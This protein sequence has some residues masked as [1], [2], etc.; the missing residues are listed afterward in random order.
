MNTT[1][2]LPAY[3]EAHNLP[4]VLE[5]LLAVFAALCY[6]E[7]QVI[8]VDDGSS[9]DTAAVA[10]RFAATGRVIVLQ[11][12]K[13]RGLAAAL[14]TGLVAASSRDGV[15]VTMDADDSHDPALIPALLAG[16]E[17]GNDVMIASRFQDGGGMVGVPAYRSLLSVAA[18]RAMR[19][20]FPDASIRDYSTGYRAYR[21]TLL[22]RLIARHGEGLLSQR[23]FAATVEILL[24]ARAEGAR[25]GEVPFVLRYDRKAGPSKMN[26]SATVAGYLRL[27]ISDFPAANL[28]KPRSTRV[29]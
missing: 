23:G 10:D 5:R 29:F 28:P 3:N 1:V 25:I 22:R 20:V 15:V 11:H 7:G 6:G 8:V 14:R 2:V 27:M 4:A 18:N 24:K 26:V 9:D 12:E 21:S 17:S 16:I 19:F 13:N